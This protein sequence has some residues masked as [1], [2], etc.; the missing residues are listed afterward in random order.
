MNI[1]SSSVWQDGIPLWDSVAR[2]SN[3]ELWDQFVTISEELHPEIPESS[4]D[5]QVSWEPA[6]PLE[7]DPVKRYHRLKQQ[8]TQLETHLKSESLPVSALEFC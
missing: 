8:L 4:W 7:Q 2:Y 6:P 5:E 3:K 1:A